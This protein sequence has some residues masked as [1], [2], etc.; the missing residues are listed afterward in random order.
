MQMSLA[1][2]PSILMQAVTALLYRPQ[3]TLLLPVLAI[4]IGLAAAGFSL[5]RPTP[6]PLLAVPPGYVA[7]VN[8][9]GILM[10]DFMSQAAVE[11][12]QPFP[13]T[14]PAQR[15]KVLRE[16]IDQELLVQRAVVL[17]L[18]ET[19]NEVRDAM[20]LGVNAQVIAPVLAYVP[21]EAEL[22]AFYAR[23]RSSYAESG[24][25]TLRDLVLHIGGYENADQSTAQGEIDAAEAVYQLRAG[26]SLGYVMA[27]F[28]LANSGRV[29]N[30]ALLDSEAKVRLGNKLYPAAAT[31]S[32]GEISDPVV[33]VDGVHILVMERH[34]FP[35]VADFTAVRDRV[36]ADFRTAE[37]SRA[38]EENLALLRSQAQILLAPG[39]SE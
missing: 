3:R 2:R 4:A 17:D 29:D 22:R 33:D 19:T 37:S 25:M 31:L 20:A 38:T 26:A 30:S 13:Q 8:Q 36:Y 9:K 1:K 6:R 12:Q 5:F 21:T 34:E 11:G 28:G 18:P 35:K 32:N 10:S 27:H 24:S 7:L 39:Q 15:S 16:M 23:H 14:T